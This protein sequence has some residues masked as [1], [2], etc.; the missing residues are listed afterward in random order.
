MPLKLP[1]CKLSFRLQMRCP[2]GI[3]IPA[4]L[5]VVFIQQECDAPYT[6]CTSPKKTPAESH[7]ISTLHA[8]LSNG[9]NM[10]GGFNVTLRIMRKDDQIVKNY[11]YSPSL[12]DLHGVGMLFAGLHLLNLHCLIQPPENHERKGLTKSSTK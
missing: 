10:N 7:K 8:D 4:V 2:M 3:Y 6:I 12:E 5:K 11:Y 9:Y 1:T